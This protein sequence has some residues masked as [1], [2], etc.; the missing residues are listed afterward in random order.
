MKIVPK[1]TN[2]LPQGLVFCSASSGEG[3]GAV[4]SAR[5]L[6]SIVQTRVHGVSYSTVRLV[7]LPIEFGIVPF[8]AG[9]PPRL[10]AWR[11][12]HRNKVENKRVK[13]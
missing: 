3:A 11:R 6:R 2:V 7:K 13:W 9:R 8:I 1:T 12:L 4:E 10:F 5:G